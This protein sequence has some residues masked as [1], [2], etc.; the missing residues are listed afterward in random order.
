MYG[1]FIG[2]AIE[3]HGLSV[4]DA[5]KAMGYT[6]PDMLYRIL[7]DEARPRLEPLQKL[8]DHINEPIGDLLPNSGVNPSGDELKTILA[9]I[10]GIAGEQRVDIVATLA[11][12]ARMLANAVRRA[13][14]FAEFAKANATNGKPSEYD[15]AVPSEK[16][17]RPG[18]R[19][20]DGGVRAGSATGVVNAAARPRR[21]ASAKGEAP[22]HHQGREK[23]R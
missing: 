5:A 11:V 21:H 10:S 15:S 4:I 20:W 9:E 8:A 22:K 16:T 17:D 23:K 18:V 7:R 6:G 14:G 3:R 12:S 19:V 1:L 2:R 13:G